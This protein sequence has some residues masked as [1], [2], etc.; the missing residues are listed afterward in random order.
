MNWIT[1][2]QKAPP[3]TSTIQV[4]IRHC[5]PQLKLKDE[6]VAGKFGDDGFYLSDGGELSYHWDIVEWRHLTPIE[7]DLE[8][9]GYCLKCGLRPCDCANLPDEKKAG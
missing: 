4:K 2:K 1:I 9:L 7:P 5:N 3:T 6:I 8:K